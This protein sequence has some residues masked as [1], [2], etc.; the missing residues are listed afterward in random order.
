[1]NN[2]IIGLVSFLVSGIL[3]IEYSFT[4]EGATGGFGMFLSIPSFIFVIGVGGG[5]NY[6]RKHTFRNGEIGKSLRNDFALAG[7]LGF[8]VGL[9]LAFGGN[10]YSITDIPST[11]ISAAIIPVLYGYV[12]GSIT[13]AFITN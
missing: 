7:W 4:V 10:S 3:A 9:V 2:K 11:Y 1:M 12:I 8:I 5:L 13:D 6:M